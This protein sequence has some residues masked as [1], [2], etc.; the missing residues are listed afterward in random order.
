MEGLNR[1]Q[2]EFVIKYQ[3]IYSKLEQ[4]ESQMK[5]IQLQTADLLNELETLR[6]AE[7]KTYNQNTQN[8]G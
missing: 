3:G 1:E 8:N 6:E 5:D 2:Q 7:N 4:L